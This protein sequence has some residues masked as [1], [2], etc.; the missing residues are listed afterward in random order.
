[1]SGTAHLTRRTMNIKKLGIGAASLAAVGALVLGGATFASAADNPTPTTQSSAGATTSPDAT[2]KAGK[3]GRGQAGQ[4]GQPGGSQDTPVTGEEATKVSA[5]VTAKDSTVTVESTTDEARARL[6]EPRNPKR[7]S[8]LADV[9]HVLEEAEQVFPYV[10]TTMMLGYEPAHALKEHTAQIRK[11]ATGKIAGRHKNKMPYFLATLEQLVGLRP[12]TSSS[13]PE[14][15]R[16]HI[17]ERRE[18]GGG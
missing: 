4:A 13:A 18:L 6:H 9:I 1:M 17:P 11:L 10:N 14:S 8:S 7:T 2:G 3:Q 15:D 12:T 16:R 5:A